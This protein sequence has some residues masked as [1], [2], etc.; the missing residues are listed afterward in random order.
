MRKLAVFVEGF[1]ELNFVE[2]L[3]SEIAGAHNINFE[4]RQIV[5]GATIPRKVISIQSSDPDLGQKFYVLL[6][7]CGGDHQVKP[8]IEEEHA[9]LTRAGFS[10]IIGL[11]DVRPMYTREQ[12]PLL[13]RNLKYGIKTSLAPVSIVLAV[14]E[15]EAWFLAEAVHFSVISEALTLDKISSAI[16]GNP[17]EVASSREEPTLD[18]QAIYGSVG[19]SY[20]KPA[21]ETINALDYSRIYLELAEKIPH[22]GRLIKEIDSFL[23]PDVNHGVPTLS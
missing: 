1:T 22:L 15:I 16:G 11:R 3:I 2:R 4:K 20:E 13:E 6:F 23:S 9:S 14:M 5:G 12:I 8:R 18:L 21:H 10:A 19:K 7:D 17:A